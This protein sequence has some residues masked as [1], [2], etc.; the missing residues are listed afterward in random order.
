MPHLPGGVGNDRDS[1]V[2]V[3]TGESNNGTGA[4]ASDRCRTRR[5]G[6]KDQVRKGVR[7]AVPDSGE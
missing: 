2:A 4:S 7:E 1:I 3:R 5:T 6:E